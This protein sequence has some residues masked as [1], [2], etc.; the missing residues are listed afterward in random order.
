M[1]DFERDSGLADASQSRE[2]AYLGTLGEYGL[3]L[4]G[5]TFEILVTL[6]PWRSG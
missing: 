2:N 3:D 4:F 1:G 6:G 5:T